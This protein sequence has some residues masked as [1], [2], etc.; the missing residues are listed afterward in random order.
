MSAPMPA[1]VQ[2]LRSLSDLPP[3]SVKGDMT[4]REVGQ[5]TI[6]VEHNGG[7]RMVRDCMDRI[8]VVYEVYSLDREQAE[9]LAFEVR[10][11]FLSGLQNLTVGSLHFL[12]SEDLQMPDYEP[13]S[14]SR[15]HV[16][17]GEVALFYTPA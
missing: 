15:E 10:E 5:T 17:S 6:Y 2:F 9:A 7:I 16:Y 8:D 4:D 3:G 13:D 1:I 12:D 14:S 11:H